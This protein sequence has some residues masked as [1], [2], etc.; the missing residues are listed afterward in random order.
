MK[1]AGAIINKSTIQG[2]KAMSQGKTSTIKEVPY[3]SKGYYLGLDYLTRNHPDNS[4][5]RS[6]YEG[7][8]FRNLAQCIMFDRGRKALGLDRYL[9]RPQR[10][11][12]ISISGK[13]TGVMVTASMPE[14]YQE[15]E[16]EDYA[17][18]GTE[19]SSNYDKF[20]SHFSFDGRAE[21]VTFDVKQAQL[22][23]S[24]F[25]VKKTHYWSVFAYRG[26]TSTD[27]SANIRL[28]DSGDFIA[29]R[30]LSKGLPEE[31]SPFRSLRFQ[32]NGLPYQ[33]YV[34]SL[35]G[36]SS[37]FVG[38]CPYS[39]RV[40]QLNYFVGSPVN[41][42]LLLTALETVGKLVQSSGCELIWRLRK[43]DVLKNKALIKRSGLVEL[44]KESHLHLRLSP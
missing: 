5:L 14:F 34:L 1:R 13:I 20:L 42:E 6:C 44:A 18:I 41:D 43:K 9:K 23:R 16:Y 29:A 3:N 10:L 2:K 38:V 30:Q 8:S 7:V 11:V 27:N 36:S 17:V 15:L 28:M 26:K 21:I 40:C 37:V 32:L 33:N 31:S 4:H 39:T 12:L 35:D 19:T 24:R 25:S 22:V